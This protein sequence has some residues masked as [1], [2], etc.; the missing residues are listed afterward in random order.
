MKMC[1]FTMLKFWIV[2]VRK[3][4]IIKKKY[5]RRVYEFKVYLKIKI[6][7]CDLSV[8]R[9]FHEKFASLC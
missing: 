5:L 8:H 9:L 4:L 2:L 7:L 6:T 1:I 3:I